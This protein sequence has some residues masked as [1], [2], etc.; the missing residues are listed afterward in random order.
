MPTRTQRHI[1][2]NG[3][4]KFERCNGESACDLPFYIRNKHQKEETKANKTPDLEI[5]SF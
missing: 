2:K 1:L 5:Q 4:K 3:I